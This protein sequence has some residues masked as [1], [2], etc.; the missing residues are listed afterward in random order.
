M[1]RILQVY[2]NSHEQE[3]YTLTMTPATRL[4]I[5]HELEFAREFIIASGLLQQ[6]DDVDIYLDE[7]H[8]TSASYCVYN[9]RPVIV[10]NPQRLRTRR[11]LLLLLLHEYRH[12]KQHRVMGDEFFSAYFTYKHVD[13]DP[14]S[15]LREIDAN[16]W[17]L[18]AESKLSYKNVVFNSNAISHFVD[19]KQY[20][21]S[22]KE[23]IG[24]DKVK[25]HL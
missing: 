4:A 10:I 14:H 3:G 22:L 16:V 8:L 17:A 21:D 25:L 19:L 23:S 13:N 9:G 24:S 7:K 11:D 6:D 2:H 1:K 12:C 18:G 20:M 15:S 5:E